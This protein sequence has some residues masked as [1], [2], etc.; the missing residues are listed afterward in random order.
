MNELR[1]IVPIVAAALTLAA[2]ATSAAADGRHRWSH[3]PIFVATPARASPITPYVFP[4][5]SRYRYNSPGPVYYHLPI[6]YPHYGCRLWR[7]NYLYWT[8]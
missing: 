8:C 4:Y 7:Y 5:G 6:W 3:P 2:A 1:R